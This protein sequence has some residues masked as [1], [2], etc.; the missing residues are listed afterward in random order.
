MFRFTRKRRSE[1]K[2]TKQMTLTEATLKSGVI[3]M[4]RGHN[5]ATAFLST[6]RSIPYSELYRQRTATMETPAENLQR[7]AEDEAKR[8]VESGQ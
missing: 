8:V 6:A 2:L 3:V 4:S 7:A 1:V 5:A